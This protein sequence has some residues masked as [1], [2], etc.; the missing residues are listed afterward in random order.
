MTKSEAR[1]IR[2]IKRRATYRALAEIYYEPK[3][4]YYGN[5]LFGSDLCLEAFKVLYPRYKKHPFQI[6]Y[7]KF[8][9]K[10]NEENKSLVG[11]FYWWE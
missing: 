1:M 4:P 11:D 2:F 7:E 10:F 5:Q 6:P 8:T 3:H 9:K